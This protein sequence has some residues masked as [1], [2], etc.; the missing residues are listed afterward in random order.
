MMHL[1]FFI[2]WIVGLSLLTRNDFKSEYKERKIDENTRLVENIITVII[3]LLPSIC[4]ISFVVYTNVYDYLYLS[5]DCIFENMEFVNGISH[6]CN[7]IDRTC[8]I[9]SIEDFAI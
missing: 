6:C 5:N 7:A 3:L 1:E 8:R 4:A 9:Y 2:Y